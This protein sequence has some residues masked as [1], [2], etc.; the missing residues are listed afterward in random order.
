MIVCDGAGTT[1]DKHS[2]WASFIYE[3]ASNTHSL[4]KGSNSF[5]TNNWAEL[6]PII[7]SLWWHMAK[8]PLD[9][10]RTYVTVLTDSELTAKCHSKE[11]TR[12][13]NLPLWSALDKLEAMKYDLSVVWIPRNSNPIH[14][15]CDR[16]AKEN[17]EKL[18]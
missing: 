16:M 8:Y 15:E 14:A 10:S 11:Y 5:G 2:G 4:L 17:K 18:K 9:T 1:F 12:K 6:L 13:S 3:R 7:S